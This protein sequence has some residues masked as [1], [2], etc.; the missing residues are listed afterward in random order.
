MK[1]KAPHILITAGPTVED[2]DPVRFISN[3]ASGKL[4]FALARAALEAGCR[5]TLIHGPVADEV[6]KTVP[7]N[8][9]LKCVAV[10]SAAQMLGAVRTHVNAVDAAIMNAAVSDFTVSKKSAVKLKK[11]AAGFMLKLKPTVDI[12]A[13]LGRIKRA[14]GKRLVLIGFALETGAG[15]SA[16]QR[17][18]SALRFARGKL[19]AKNLDAIVLN[20]PVSIGADSGDF[21]LIEGANVR[22]LAGGKTQFARQLIESV[23]RYWD[24]GGTHK[25]L[26]TEC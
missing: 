26:R 7:K 2:L 9:R 18:S 12:L 14:R 4:G 5:V 3:R 24:G 15:A 22:V 19:K 10:R 13:E 23:L 21:K 6:L 16:S 8:K 17:R 25:K 20:S 11:S 1:I